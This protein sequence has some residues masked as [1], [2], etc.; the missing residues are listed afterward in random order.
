MSKIEQPSIIISGGGPAGLLTAILLNNIGIKST[1][2]ERS[3]EIDPWNTKSYTIVLTDQGKS[4][5]ERAGCL[6]AARK[7]CN[8]RHFVYIING[9]TGDQHAISKK[10]PGYD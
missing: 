8:E 9:K 2:L 1:V 5:L 3:I 6:D 10:S 7:A 4:A